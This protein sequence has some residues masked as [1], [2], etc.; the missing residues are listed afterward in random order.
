MLKNA[1]PAIVAGA[2]S[3]LQVQ[4]LLSPDQIRRLRFA[5]L[6]MHQAYDHARV[7]FDA[8]NAAC[9]T[10]MQDAVETLLLI[11]AE[12]VDATLG[13]R[14][15]FDKYFQHINAKISPATLPSHSALMRLNRMRVSAKHAGVFP[16]HNQVVE[17]MPVVTEFM[18]EVCEAYLGVSW[19]TAN[20]AS[21]VENDA[22]KRLLQ[23]AETYLAE[24]RFPEAMIAARKAFFLAFEK[25]FD[26][27]AFD[28]TQ[29]VN[30]FTTF[31][32]DA[33]SWAK[34]RDYIANHVGDP[35]GYIVIDHNVLEA[36]LFRLGIDPV[37]FWNVWRLTPA[38][39]LTKDGRW[40]LKQDYSKIGQPD[41]ESDS[42]YVV[43][44][45]TAFILR[46]EEK[47][48]MAKSI[49]LTTDWQLIPNPG[50]KIYAKADDQ[51]DVRLI[52]EG[53]EALRVNAATCGFDGEG[54]W[55]DVFWTGKGQVVHGFIR[56]PDINRS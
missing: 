33:P 24:S 44:T 40:L 43:E 49:V 47:E 29:P 12:K 34:S 38:V 53:N 20:L 19:H 27:S 46:K 16:S 4:K 35:F 10:S 17:L 37:A 14:P 51:S 54:G 15:D 25:S 55:W 48:R 22:Q 13:N 28:G 5:R 6:L 30:A 7:D 50:G 31:G 8:R 11:V 3:V 41:P 42:I 9:L 1:N 2:S 32:C 18:V 56:E 21:M 26:I 52:C 23:E 39:Y 45:V 36:K